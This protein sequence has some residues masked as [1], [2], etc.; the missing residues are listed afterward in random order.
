MDISL[1]VKKVNYKPNC[2]YIVSCVTDY[3]I[4]ES[5]NF[6]TI[7]I[8]SPDNTLTKRINLED[9]IITDEFVYDKDGFGNNETYRKC[10]RGKNLVV[11]RIYNEYMF[12]NFIFDSNNKLKYIEVLSSEA[13]Y[14]IEIIEGNKLI[15]SG[16]NPNI[17]PE[18]LEIALGMRKMPDKFCQFEY[19]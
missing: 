15:I 1:F 9:D 2:S 6:I 12:E 11:G 3:G 19:M 4:S 8:Y 18:H 16:K 17:Q 7:K 14:D 5:T 10:I 13:N